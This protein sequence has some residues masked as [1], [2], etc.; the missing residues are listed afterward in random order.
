MLGPSFNFLNVKIIIYYL[1]R[2]SFVK[3]S[4]YFVTG[5]IVGISKNDKNCF[6]VGITFS[7]RFTGIVY[8]IAIFFYFLFW[9]WASF[10]IGYNEIS[11]TDNCKLVKTHYKFIENTKKH[12]KC[13]KKNI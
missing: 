12:Y 6:S 9:I 8:V 7:Y 4:T 11:C 5:F 3:Q 2:K 13:N 1:F 10:D